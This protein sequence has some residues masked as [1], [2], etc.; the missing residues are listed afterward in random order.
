MTASGLDTPTSD[1][2]PNPA[3]DLAG[4]VQRRA[5]DIGDAITQETMDGRLPE[6]TYARSLSTTIDLTSH[7]ETT[8]NVSSFTANYNDKVSHQPP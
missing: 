7:E 3:N 4:I 8:E 6:E 2:F 5:D 1:D